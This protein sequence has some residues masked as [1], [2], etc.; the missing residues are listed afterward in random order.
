MWRGV[1]RIKGHPSV[2]YHDERKQVVEDWTKETEINMKS[3]KY[4]FDKNNEK[5]LSE[6][7]RIMAANPP[8]VSLIVTGRPDADEDDALAEYLQH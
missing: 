8:S 1:I 5:T 7:R 3:G 2:C 6:L 4:D